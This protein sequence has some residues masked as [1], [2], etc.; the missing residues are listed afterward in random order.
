MNIAINFLDKKLL[1]YKNNNATGLVNKIIKFV[2]FYY[3]IFLQA[4]VR[5]LYVQIDTAAMWW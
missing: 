2:K 3:S 1:L 5:Q 4:G